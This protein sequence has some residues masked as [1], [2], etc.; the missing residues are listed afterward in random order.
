MDEG[1]AGYGELVRRAWRTGKFL[2][3]GPGRP[4]SLLK[5]AGTLGLQ[6]RPRAGRGA[7]GRGGEKVPE[8]RRSVRGEMEEIVKRESA[9]ALGSLAVHQEGTMK[10]APF[11]KFREEKFGAVLFE[12]RSEKVFTLNKTGAAVVRAI[13]AG[14]GEA[15]LVAR[16]RERCEDK[17]GKLEA[18]ALSFL[19]QLKKKGLVTE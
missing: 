8:A 6:P 9:E 17:T 13:L 1:L 5:A 19:K 11:V 4:T 15:D 7:P 10:L 16:L 18:E 14:A 3:K 2:V 12:T